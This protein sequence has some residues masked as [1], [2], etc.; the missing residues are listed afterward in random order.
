M[1]EEE[2]AS[3]CD[4]RLQLPNKPLQWQC[5]KGSGQRTKSIDSEE[6]IQLHLIY[7]MFL[8]G[9]RWQW[10]SIFF[11]LYYICAMCAAEMHHSSHFFFISGKGSCTL[12][13]QDCPL[14]GSQVIY[15]PLGKTA[16]W[17]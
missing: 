1:R 17:D 13:F 3:R 4:L 11:S 7:F 8:T 2:A 5:I 10:Q 9:Q 6:W 16:V 12:L 15:A 14:G